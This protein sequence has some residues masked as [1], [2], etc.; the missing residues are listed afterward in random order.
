MHLQNL[1]GA[2]FICSTLFWA[3]PEAV[4]HSPQS[5]GQSELLALHEAEI[6]IY[7][8]PDAQEVRKQGMEVGWELQTGPDFDQKDF[9]VFWVVNATRPHVHGSRTL[10]YYAVN[11]HTADVSDFSIEAV[12]QFVLSKELEGVRRI[13]RKA[14]HIDDATITKYRSRH[15]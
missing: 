3:A 2:F 9:F 5:G 7:L 8:L 14:H 12:N 11:R 15:P 13:L 10:G 4:P 6:L 1:F